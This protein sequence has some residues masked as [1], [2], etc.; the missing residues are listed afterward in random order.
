MSH[1]SRRDFLKSSFAA[2]VTFAVG[3]SAR[4][5]LGANDTINMGVAGIN[6]R[7]RSHMGAW[8]G[9]KDV[10]IT[11]LIDPDS[12]IHKSRS[13]MCEKK[14]NPKPTCVTDI[15]KA[16]EDKDLDGVSVATCNH[17]HSL[18]SIWACQAGKDVYVEKPASHNVHE[19]RILLETAR[20]HGRMVQHGS[21][22]RASSSWATATAHARTGKLGKLLVSYGVASKPRGSIGHRPYSDPPKDLDFN[23]WLG[24]APMQRFHANL[25]HYNWHWFWDFGNADTGNQGVHQMDLARWGTPGGRLPNRIMSL[26]GRFQWNDQGETPNSHLTIFEYDD[27][28]FQLIFE[29]CNLVNG[30]TRVVNNFFYTDQGEI[31]SGGFTPKGSKKR[32]KLPKADIDMG[33][34][35]NIF[36]NFIRAMRSRKHT[37]LVAD[38][39]EAHLS[40]ALCHLGAIC[41][42]LGK[43][44]PFDKSRK[45]FG[46]NKEAYEALLKMEERMK[47]RK[48]KIDDSLKYQVGPVLTFDPETEKFTGD[49]AAAANKLLTRNYR[50]PFVVPDKVVV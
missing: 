11:H 39:K 16:L 33:A 17:W 3:T 21:Q 10:H 6:G 44:V 24:P 35:G 50:K 49:H 9:M 18:I 43:V 4:P 31:T 13:R 2:G 5:V 47:S 20:K 8:L 36:D 45:A 14:N 29:S 25:V 22:S 19:G 46:D 7:G 12:R 30:K 42:R 15:R 37:D 38:V 28:D 40:S 32:Q 48:V 23:I 27:A 26:G 1:V 34:G 41:Y